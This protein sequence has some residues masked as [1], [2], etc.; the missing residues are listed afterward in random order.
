MELNSVNSGLAPISFE[1]KKRLSKYISSQL[2]L[3]PCTVCCTKVCGYE[4]FSSFYDYNLATDR[5]VL[6]NENANYNII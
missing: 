5:T 1:K 6:S 3:N 4:H 2:F